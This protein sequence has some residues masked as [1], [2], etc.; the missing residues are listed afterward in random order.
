[1]GKISQ[2]QTG[3]RGIRAVMLGVAAGAALALALRQHDAVKILG[4]VGKLSVTGQAVF[5]QSLSLPGRAVT[6]DALPACTGVGL[7]SAQCSPARLGIKVTRAEHF[8]ATRHPQ[9]SEQQQ[10][11]QHCH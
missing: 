2:I 5:C 8:P 3:Q 1:M 7:H 9:A 11:E 6:G 4:I 10:S